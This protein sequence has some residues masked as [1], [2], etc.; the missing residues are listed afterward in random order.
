VKVTKLVHSCILVEYD[1]KKALVDPGNYSWNSGVIEQTLLDGIDY[2][3]VTHA[4]PDHIDPLFASA[5][6]ERSPRAVWYV[7]AATKELL[8]S[9]AE[10][11]IELQSNHPDIRYVESVH[12]DLTN[13]GACKDHTS[14]VL[15]EDLLITGDCHTLTSMHGASVLAAAINGGPWGSVTTFLNMIASMDEVPAKVLP[16]HDWHW[17]E[18]ARGNFYLGLVSAL[19]KLGVQF[20]PLEVGIQTE[21]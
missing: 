21:V 6:H 2:V 3:L 14:F 12:A 18:Q 19:E 5:V 4:H 1:G 8:E 11:N 7:T 20:V 10:M 16:L 17:N 9:P 13:W 15:F